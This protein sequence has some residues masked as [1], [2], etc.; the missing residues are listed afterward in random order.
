[1][2]L[3]GE[4]EGLVE[5][6]L[7]ALE[8]RLGLGEVVSVRGGDREARPQGGEL[9]GVLLRQRDGGRQI[10]GAGRGAAEALVVELEGCPEPLP[11]GAHGSSPGVGDAWR[12]LRAG[13]Q[14]M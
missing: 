12:R 10:A 11:V 3:G 7:V 4:R 14:G 2:A 5:E 8:R 9:G 13:T 6:S 1:V